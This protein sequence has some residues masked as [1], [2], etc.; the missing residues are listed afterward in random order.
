[1]RSATPPVRMSAR[2][3]ESPIGAVVPA[4][5][6]ATRFGSRKLLADVGGVPLLERTLT[7]LLQAGVDRVILVV[8]DGDAF[9]GVGALGDPRV[10]MVGN[11]DPERGMFSSIQAGLAAIS[12]LGPVLVIPADMPFVAAATVAA[13]AGRAAA[14]DDVVIPVH[15]GR[16]GHPI[17]LP[18]RLRAPLLA[19]DPTT[20]LKM[21]LARLHPA[22]T[23]IEVADPGIVRDVDTPADLG[24]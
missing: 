10:T 5:G 16:R 14:S 11:P 6:A 23:L 21:A 9:D 18:G 4:A 24:R 15:D 22:V 19:L 8:R 20:T 17:A 12:G 7:S 2:M 3:T 13:I 1:M